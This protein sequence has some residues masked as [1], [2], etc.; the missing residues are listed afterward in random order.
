MSM[1]MK[2]SKENGHKCELAEV[3]QRATYVAEASCGCCV[4]CT[5]ICFA[6]VVPIFLASLPSYSVNYIHL[7]A[8]PPAAAPALNRTTGVVII[9]NNNN[10]NNNNSRRLFF[11]LRLHNKMKLMSVKYDDLQLSFFFGGMPIGNATLPGFEQPRGHTT[12]KA[13]T[14][15]V[16]DPP[17]GPV[18]LEAAAEA[19]VVLRVDLVTVVRYK[20]LFWYGKRRPFTVSNTAILPPIN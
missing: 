4:L 11:S 2:K 10:N 15:Y 19:A 3:R 20:S 17:Q 13:G 9:G 16:V 12:S 6:L 1:M 8:P 14:V 5:A 18:L 7:P